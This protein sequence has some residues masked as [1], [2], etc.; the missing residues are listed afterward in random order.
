[1]K[2]KSNLIDLSER[3]YFLEGS[4]AI[5]SKY[6]NNKRYFTVFEGGCSYET[7]RKDAYFQLQN[8]WTDA[9]F[10]VNHQHYQKSF[11]SIQACFTYGY[12]TLITFHVTI[13]TENPS[14]VL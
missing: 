9:Y 8:W 7:E 5:V 1:M 3:Q 12:N 2:P 13:D 6:T 10:Q 11:T 14:S 4:S